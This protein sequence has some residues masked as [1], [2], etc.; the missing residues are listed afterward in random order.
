MS[1]ARETKLL[2]NLAP[3]R[4]RMTAES[5]SHHYYCASL[6]EQGFGLRETAQGAVAPIRERSLSPN[7]TRHMACHHAVQTQADKGS[8]RAFRSSKPAAKLC[9]SKGGELEQI[10]FLLGHESIL[11]TERYL[12]SKQY[13]KNA[14]ND[15]LVFE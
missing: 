6:R 2:L 3:R 15:A 10:Q 9:R 11:T 1:L 5:R 4:I 12:G 7:Q 14:V 8:T 13:L